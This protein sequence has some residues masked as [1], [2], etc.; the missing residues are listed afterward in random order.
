MR[1]IFALK[2]DIDNNASDTIFLCRSLCSL[3][4][5]NNKSV[6]VPLA[7]IFYKF[8]MILEYVH[9]SWHFL[10]ITSQFVIIE[11]NF[12]G[13][14]VLYMESTNEYMLL[15]ENNDYTIIEKKCNVIKTIVVV[16]YQQ[17]YS[18]ERKEPSRKSTRV[19]LKF[20]KYI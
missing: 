8:Q 15:E 19:V 2:G 3:T 4:S 6:Y 14:L 1:S 18:N 12:M 5:L 20:F 7:I 13:F 11:F 10:K 16:Y 9:L 17:T